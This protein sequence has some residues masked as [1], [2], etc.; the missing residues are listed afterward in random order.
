MYKAEKKNI[1]IDFYIK[2]QFEPAILNL[3]QI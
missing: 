2:F 3:G 1:T